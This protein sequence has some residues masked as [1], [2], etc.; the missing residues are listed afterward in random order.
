MCAAAFLTELPHIS[1]HNILQNCPPRSLESYT[2]CE[3]CSFQCSLQ[4]N[5]QCSS[6]LLQCQAL[7]TKLLQER[8]IQSAR[9]RQG[10]CIDF[11][12]VNASSFSQRETARGEPKI[13]PRPQTAP[14][15]ILGARPG[16]GGSPTSRYL[17]CEKDLALLRMQVSCSGKETQTGWGLNYCCQK[18]R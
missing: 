3:A 11:T 8:K 4:V 5:S 12:K 15:A 6:A 10:E 1:F 14:S 13:P 7:V 17:C 2:P 9:V 18:C 16:V